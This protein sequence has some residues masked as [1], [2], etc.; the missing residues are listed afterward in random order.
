[1]YGFLD[2]ELPC[3]YYKDLLFNLHEQNKY[4]KLQLSNNNY[5]MS[6]QHNGGMSVQQPKHDDSMEQIYRDLNAF[7]SKAIVYDSLLKV[8]FGLMFVLILSV[9]VVCLKK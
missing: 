3:E 1:M 9:I 8:V 7:K 4:L 2:H 5:D 6:L